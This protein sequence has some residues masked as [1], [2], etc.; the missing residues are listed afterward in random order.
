MDAGS[1]KIPHVVT[2]LAS[3]LIVE[4]GKYKIYEGV[5]WGEPTLVGAKRL[6]QYFDTTAFRMK[7]D[8]S[9]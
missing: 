7:L 6:F 2:P 1:A 9:S 5:S 3:S 8:T 4:I